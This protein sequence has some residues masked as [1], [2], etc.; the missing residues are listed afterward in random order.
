[1]LYY[2]L[3]FLAIALIA[4]LLGMSGVAGL[5]SQIAWVLFAIGI[6]LL[7]VNFLTGN[8]PRSVV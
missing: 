1:M 3:T 5:A 8:R 2:A 6:I 4:A 7:V